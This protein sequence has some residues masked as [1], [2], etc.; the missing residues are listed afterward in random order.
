MEVEAE[1][2]SDSEEEMEVEAAAAVAGVSAATAAEEERRECVIC[3]DDLSS[4]PEA[5]LQPRDPNGWGATRCCKNLFHY[6]CLHAWLNNDSEV[7][8]SCGMEPINTA[9]PCCRGFV[10]KSASRMLQ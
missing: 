4:H 5:R 1:Q 10:S 2:E 7:E 9:C 6:R 8:T 3:F